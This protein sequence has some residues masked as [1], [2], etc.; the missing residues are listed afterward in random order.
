MFVVFQPLAVNKQV[1]GINRVEKKS[2]RQRDK[3]LEWQEL[4]LLYLKNISGPSFCCILSIQCFKPACSRAAHKRL[5]AGVLDTV[6]QGHVCSSATG[7][8]HTRPH[9]HS[10]GFLHTEGTSSP[11]SEEVTSLGLAF[12]DRRA[13]FI[14]WKPNSCHL[15]G[16][17]NIP[18]QT[19]DT[20]Q[21]NPHLFPT[22]HSDSQQQITP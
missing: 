8:W 15:E 9:K 16:W 13:V 5:A 17:H 7:H 19:V 4:P 6:L 2:P 18:F 11:F 10:L 1:S 22:K 21:D 3:F 12:G 14:T 20:G